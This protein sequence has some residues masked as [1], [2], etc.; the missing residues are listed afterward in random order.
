MIVSSPFEDLI[1]G[2]LLLKKSETSL[3][4]TQD[5]SSASALE[6]HDVDPKECSKKR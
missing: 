5:P 1:K 3:E 4:T 2:L 6:L